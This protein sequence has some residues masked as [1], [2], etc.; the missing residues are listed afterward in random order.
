MSP[1]VFKDVHVFAGLLDVRN[2]MSDIVFPGPLG[3]R[4]SL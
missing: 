4:D 3:V 1:V 2:L